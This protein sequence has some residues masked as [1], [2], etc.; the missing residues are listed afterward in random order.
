MMLG[1][2]PLPISYD[3]AKK[4]ALV[5]SNVLAE[6]LAKLHSQ[7][8]NN[9]CRPVPLMLTDGRFMLSADILTEIGPGGLLHDMWE[10]SDKSVIMTNVEVM[11]WHE[12]VSMLPAEPMLQPSTTSINE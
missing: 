7:Y 9:L 2:L 1:E 6:K 12:A 10:A 3:E 4:W 8:G 5:F 11:S